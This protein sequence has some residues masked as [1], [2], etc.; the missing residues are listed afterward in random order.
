PLEQNTTTILQVAA[1]PIH[2]PRHHQVV[3]ALGGIAQQSVK[4]R[5]PVPAFSATDAV[6]LVDADDLTAHA[7]GDLPQLSLLIGRGLVCGGNP[8]VENGALHRNP[9]L[10]DG[11]SIA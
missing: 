6:V 10:I 7:A 5:P 4:F 3:L 11:L 2:R 1:E 9:R 8:K